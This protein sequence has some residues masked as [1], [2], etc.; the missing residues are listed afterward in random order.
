[1]FDF[2]FDADN[3]IL[4]NVTSIIAIVLFLY[5]LFSY[6][7]KRI[8]NYR[9]KKFNRPMDVTEEEVER[10]TKYY[11]KTKFH[12]NSSKKYSITKFMKKCMFKGTAQYHFILGDAGT[13]KSTF[14]LNLFFMLNGRILNKGY[15]AEYVSLRRSDALQKISAIENKKNKILLLDAF[16]ESISSS[17]NAAQ[18]LTSIENSTEVFA[19]IVIASRKHFF[20]S[21]TDEPNT[22]LG[23]EKSISLHDAKYNKHY[24]RPFSTGN[25]LRYLGKKFR[26]NLT[27]R[28]RALRI[29]RKSA[30]IM[31]RPLLL[32]YI[33]DLLSN[34]NGYTYSYEVFDVLVDKWVAREVEFLKGKSDN[35]AEFDFDLHEKAYHFLINWIT[36]KIYM[37]AQINGEYTIATK[38][39]DGLYDE[40]IEYNEQEHKSDGLNR[41]ISVAFDKRI[42][43]LLQRKNDNELE[44]CQ[45]SIF[46][47]LLAK[48]FKD[49]RSYKYG[50]TL[51]QVPR[52]LMEGWFLENPIVLTE[53]PNHWYE[54]VHRFSSMNS[55]VEITGKD[56]DGII[57]EYR[58]YEENDI[59]MEMDRIVDILITLFDDKPC[60]RSYPLAIVQQK[61]TRINVHIQ[62][63]D[64]FRYFEVRR[65]FRALSNHFGFELK[66]IDYQQTWGG[67]T[68]IQIHGHYD[69]L[70][71]LKNPKKALDKKIKELKTMP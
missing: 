69:V 12:D 65:I 9:N 19:K 41:S 39:V 6:A 62:Y 37:N 23:V 21:E 25:V 42:R 48:N 13:G 58:R 1:M 20:D 40:L 63:M 22:V 27:K 50:N 30:D 71:S 68:S 70:Y 51:K 29:V 26:L 60:L 54:N 36:I 8:I 46:E 56:E 32:S 3:A 15:K 35:K 4:G 52:F 45:Q 16:D 44:F 17:H 34:K 61:I 67:M 66:F 11:I 55:T 28:F 47:F 59:R 24:I 64:L 43:S 49:V 31:A 7:I 53:A 38:D 18:F 5:G 33:D 10:L 2:L 14:L 57:L